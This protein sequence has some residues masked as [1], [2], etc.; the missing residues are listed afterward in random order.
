MDTVD[1][2]RIYRPTSP[3]ACTYLCGK[4]GFVLNGRCVVV[5]RP[6]EGGTHI[7]PPLFESTSWLHTRLTENRPTI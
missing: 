3:Q 5:I 2:Y 4:E 7:T 1:K 6:Y